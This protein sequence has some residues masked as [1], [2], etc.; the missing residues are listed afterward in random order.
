M[1][2]MTPLDVVQAFFG[3]WPKGMEPLK[4]AFTDWLATDVLYENVGLTRTTTLDEAR[5][6]IETFVPGLDNIGVDVLEIAQNGDRVFTE[7]IDYLRKEDGTVLATIRVMGIF[8]VRGGR[9]AEW[10]DYFHTAPFAVA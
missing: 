8:V 2:S 3:E 4:Q 9:I 6:L 5:A 1:T 7:R 10:R